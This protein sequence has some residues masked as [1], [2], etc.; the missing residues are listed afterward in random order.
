[1]GRKSNL[2]VSYLDIEKSFK[3][4]KGK[5]NYDDFEDIPFDG[6][7]E[8]VNSQVPASLGFAC[9]DE[10]LVFAAAL[11]HAFFFDRSAASMRFRVDLER[12]EKSPS[13][14]DEVMA[15]ELVEIQEGTIDIALNL[16]SNN[17]GVVLMGDGLMIQE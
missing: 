16:E 15:G 10:V 11:L 3:K 2:D 12:Y 5:L 8:E 14:L 1:M 7:I 6:S 9:F 17:V 13:K 4:N